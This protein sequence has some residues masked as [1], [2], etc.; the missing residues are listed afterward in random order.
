MSVLRLKACLRLPLNQILK[1]LFFLTLHFISLTMIYT[2]LWL[3]HKRRAYEWF[4]GRHPWRS[5][6]T[7]RK[8]GLIYMLFSL[9]LKAVG[10]Q[11]SITLWREQRWWNSLWLC[12]KKGI[13][14]HRFFSGIKDGF[15][16][17]YILLY[18]TTNSWFFWPRLFKTPISANPRL[19]M[20]IRD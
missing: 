11:W 16:C 8:F 1:C 3:K 7:L 5:T 13:W 12:N 17:K 20:L 19:N 15:L 9:F 2:F 10:C 4:F 18:S 6:V 14:L